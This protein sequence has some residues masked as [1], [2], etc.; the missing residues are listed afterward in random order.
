[1]EFCACVAGYWTCL[2]MESLPVRAFLGRCSCYWKCQEVQFGPVLVYYIHVDSFSIL[3]LGHLKLVVDFFFAKWLMFFLSEIRQFGLIP[4]L[5]GV[6]KLA[7]SFGIVQDE[8]P[9]LRKI[10]KLAEYAS[11]N[12]MRIPKIASAL[13]QKGQKELQNK[14]HGSVHAVMAT[15]SR[16]FM[17][18]R[19]QMY[20]VV[21]TLISFKVESPLLFPPQSG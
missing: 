19:D 7:F 17:T 18:C 5:T 20:V 1:M 2:G 10:S 9:N 16:L 6:L 13:E 8:A 15:Y 11:K 21:L 12:P 14:H 3:M 4:G